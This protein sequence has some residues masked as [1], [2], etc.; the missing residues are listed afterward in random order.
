MDFRK[1]IDF[2]RKIQ[3]LFLE[4]KVNAL[5]LLLIYVYIIIFLFKDEQQPFATLIYISS[6]P[7][8]VPNT[9]STD[10]RLPIT[11]PI[12]PDGEA[13]LLLQPHDVKKE[14]NRLPIADGRA[15]RTI[16]GGESGD[17][18]KYSCSGCSQIYVF[19]CES[20][21]LSVLIP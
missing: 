5:S 1:A 20:I 13:P 15:K 16:A 3:L 17:R 7:S 4:K 6:Q 11:P 21:S 12:P 2:W 9:S 19:K 14:E 18:P 10:Y 8:P